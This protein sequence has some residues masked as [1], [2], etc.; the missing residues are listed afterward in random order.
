VGPERAKKFIVLANWKMNKTLGQ[1]IA[2][3]RAL[4]QGFQGFDS[5]VEIIFSSLDGID[6]DRFI[7]STYCLEAEA[8]SDVLSITREMA[9]G[10]TTGT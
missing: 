5:P 8:S 2:Y 4:N 3:V 9:I 7:V 10:Q 1:G 6:L